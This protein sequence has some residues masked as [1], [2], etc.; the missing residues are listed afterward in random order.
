MMSELGGYGD[1]MRNKDHS[2][3]QR[4]IFE[5]DL[6]GQA[7]VERLTQVA[8]VRQLQPQP[9]DKQGVRLFF[10]HYN[11]DN[12]RFSVGLLTFSDASR[13]VCS[14]LMVEMPLM[15]VLSSSMR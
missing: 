2:M 12:C 11:S 15:G 7:L 4:G 9:I 1:P 6:F 13:S 5:A 3:P 10:Y 14:L 8:R